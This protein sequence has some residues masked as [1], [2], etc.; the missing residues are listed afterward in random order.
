M[1]RVAIIN[2][3]FRAY[4]DLKDFHPGRESMRVWV[5]IY[6]RDK[7]DEFER[8]LDVLFGGEV[9]AD[10]LIS[11]LVNETEYIYFR[12]GMFDL[13]K[14]DFYKKLIAKQ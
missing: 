10:H 13:C 3:Q 14:T 6:D 8:I 12:L 4:V 1:A 5:N 11:F 9:D 7:M 2:K